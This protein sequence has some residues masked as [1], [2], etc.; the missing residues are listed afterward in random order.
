VNCEIAASGIRN[1]GSKS[2]F[3]SAVKDLDLSVV[4]NPRTH[5]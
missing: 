4:V 1:P 3:R 2:V 5:C